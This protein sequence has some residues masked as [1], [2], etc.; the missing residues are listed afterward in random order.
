MG[1]AQAR[2]NLI[3]ILLARAYDVIISDYGPVDLQ[4]PAVDP[5]ARNSQF[6]VDSSMKNL[7]NRSPL[8]SFLE[9]V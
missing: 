5:L 8:A 2:P 4:G 9:K 3:Q 7:A 6:A 1:L